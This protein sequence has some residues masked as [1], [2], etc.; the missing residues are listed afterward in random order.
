GRPLIAPRASAPHQGEPRPVS[1]GT[2]VTPPVESTLRAI[3]S[4][5][6]AS[7]STPRP[8]RSHWIAAPLT[9]TAPSSAYPSAAAVFSSPCG[10][11]VASLPVCTSTKLPVPYVAFPAPAAW[12]PCPYSAACWSPATP[13]IATRRPSRSPS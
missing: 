4:L 7:A 10:G 9:S 6:A 13:L 8:S 12:Q 5:S 1:A 11:G 3:A 2:K